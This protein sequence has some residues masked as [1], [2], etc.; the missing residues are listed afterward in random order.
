MAT[1]DGVSRPRSNRSVV[2]QAIVDLCAANR[3]AS[4]KAICDYTDLP[5]SI[6]DDHVK[7]LKDD[8][9]IRVVVAGIFEPVDQTP[10]RPIS[11]TMIPNGLYKLEIGDMV[12]QLTMREA[13]AAP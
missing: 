2:Y 6:V 12:I 10:D 3:Q 13:R 8:G 4:R 11:G 9:V 5:L 1:Q 7:N